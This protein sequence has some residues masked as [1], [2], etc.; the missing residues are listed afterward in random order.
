MMVM[1]LGLLAAFA[2]HAQSV[3][4]PASEQNQPPA[5]TPAAEQPD[6]S[7]PEKAIVIQETTDRE[8]VKAEYAWLNS[9]YPGC[10]MM[11]QTLVSGK[12]KH[13][14]VLHIKTADGQ[15]KDVFFDISKFYGHL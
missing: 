5:V 7:S 11:K 2:G 12:G 3:A 13:Y 10:K 8:G 14:D 15:E 4:T 6:G 1:G 9:H